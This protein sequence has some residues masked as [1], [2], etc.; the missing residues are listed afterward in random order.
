MTVTTTGLPEVDQSF[1]VPATAEQLERTAAALRENGFTVEIADTLA[2]ARRFVHDL[3]PADQEVFTS[4][5][6]TLRAAGL[7]EDIDASGRFQSLRAA[8]DGWDLAARFDEVRKT[9]SVPDVIVG[10]VHAVTEHGQVVTVSASGSQLAPY[11][12]GAGRVV[13][14]IGAQKIVADLDTALRRANTYSLP[15]E[16]ARAQEAYGMR[17]SIGQVLIANRETIPGRTTIVLVREPAGY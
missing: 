11:A 15:L 8:Q 10:S 7:A 16:D 14:V 3:L 2:D 6:E 12:F 1:A 13:W 4:T 5:S 17:S 9:R